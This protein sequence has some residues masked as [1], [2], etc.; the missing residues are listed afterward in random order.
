MHDLRRKASEGYTFERV[1]PVVE[2]P[3][4]AVELQKVL[5]L[6]DELIDILQRAPQ[7]GTWPK[8]LRCCCCKNKER[9][10]CCGFKQEVLFGQIKQLG[11]MLKT[12]FN[13]EHHWVR[14]YDGVKL[15]CMF[16][17]Q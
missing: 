1:F 2:S 14:S 8:W 13:A 5:P 6:C 7:M 15:D 9:T 17:K 16:F 12:Q 10:S 3:Q 11:I 4:D